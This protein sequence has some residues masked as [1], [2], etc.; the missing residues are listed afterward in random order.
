MEPTALPDPGRPVVLFLARLTR[1][2][3]ASL[4]LRAA[5]RSWIGFR[6]RA[7]SSLERVTRG[8]LIEESAALGVAKSVFFPKS[9]RCSEGS[10]V[11]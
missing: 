4:L 10:G 3:G 5:P 1:Q 9:E 2:K 7:W 8:T 11:S 6:A